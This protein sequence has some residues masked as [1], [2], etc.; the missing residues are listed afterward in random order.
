[1]PIAPFM[2]PQVPLS[3]EADSTWLTSVFPLQEVNI[4]VQMKLIP[5]IFPGLTGR[6]GTS[7]AGASG[8]SAPL[9]KPSSPLGKSILVFEAILRYSDATFLATSLEDLTGKPKPFPTAKR[10]EGD[11][12]D[13]K[14]R[15]QEHE[16]AKCLLSLAMTVGASESSVESTSLK[17]PQHPAQASSEAQQTAQRRVITFN[18][19][20]AIF[21]FPRLEQYYANPNIHKVP[22]AGSSQVS[23]FEYDD[24]GNVPMDLTKPREIAASK[25][26]DVVTTM[27]PASLLISLVSI[28]DKIPASSVAGGGTSGEI[29]ESKLLQEYLTERA[30]QGSKMKQCQKN[31][32]MSNGNVAF[33]TSSAGND[34][35]GRLPR[36]ME[37][38]KTLPS[39]SIENSTKQPSSQSEECSEK[40]R[41]SINNNN[42]P[43]S[44][45][46]KIATSTTNSSD[47]KYLHKKF[48]RIASATV[49]ESGSGKAIGSSDSGDRVI[50]DD[51]E[52]DGGKKKGIIVNGVEDSKLVNNS[53]ASTD[54]L[55][56][57][58]EVLPNKIPI[59]QIQPQVQA[60][61]VSFQ[62]SAPSGQCPD[63]NPPSSG[64]NV[65][66]YC[67]LNCTK[68][69]V[70]QKHI[71]SHTNE[72]PYPCTPCGFAFKTK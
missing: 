13:S 1:M 55:I 12:D 62:Q 20:P 19:P 15:L 68:P 45:I 4:E 72:R 3:P 16:A 67:N 61:S 53:S 47:L 24:T 42:S 39:Q 52:V 31:E 63:P 7:G 30:L 49:D 10:G 29:D 17:S 28:T 25:V 51:I 22:A 9:S 43:S 11:A 38:V 18:S 70:L 66:Q 60:N 58:Q 32:V 41:N 34:P 23:A 56:Q 64:R 54:I 40:V 26:A 48:K 21:D 65:C 50:R 57:R 36:M 27:E 44:G 37:G 8:T 33:V 6:A 59:V 5:A 46:S 2:L 69:S 35:G 14:S 71:R